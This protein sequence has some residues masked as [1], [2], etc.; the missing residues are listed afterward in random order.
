MA[1]PPLLSTSGETVPWGLFGPLLL[2]PPPVRDWFWSNVLAVMET[3]EP[4]LRIGASDAASGAAVAADGLIAGEGG[5]G[6]DDAGGKADLKTAAIGD[7]VW[8][9]VARA[10]QVVAD[11]AVGDTRGRVRKDAPAPAKTVA[12][13]VTSSGQVVADRAATDRGTA[14]Q[15]VDATAIRVAESRRTGRTKGLVAG[16]LAA[17]DRQGAPQVLKAPT[18]LA[19]VL[20]GGGG[21]LEDHVLGQ[22]VPGQGQVTPVVQNA[23]SLVES[24][25]VRDR[26]AADAHVQARRDLDHPAGVVATDRELIGPQSVDG[27]THGDQQFAAGQR[28]GLTLELGRKVDAVAAGGRGDGGPKRARAAVIVVHD[29]QVAEQRA[30]F[31][32]INARRELPATGSHPRPDSR[33]RHQDLR[34]IDVQ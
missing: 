19:G 12:A 31:H 34:P 15:D 30:V 7:V 17:G 27:H 28:N 22:V 5:A 32:Q 8:R 14:G 11:G 3:T 13:V 25:A 26:Q 1:P 24:V 23:A 21:G 2:P 16:D 18:A 6:D 33:R 20:G 4:K 9:V 10:S 29:R